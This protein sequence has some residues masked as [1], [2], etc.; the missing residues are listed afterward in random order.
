[1]TNTNIKTTIERH[2]NGYTV[3]HA[4]AGLIIGKENYTDEPREIRVSVQTSLKVF[5]TLEE[6]LE[7][8]QDGQDEVEK[9]LILEGERREKYFSNRPSKDIK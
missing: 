5:L 9:K 4:G 3:V 6:V 2:E 1:M 7:S 8:V